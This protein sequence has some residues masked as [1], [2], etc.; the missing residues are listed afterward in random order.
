MEY[1]LQIKNLHKRYKK[2]EFKLDNICLDIPK[3]TVMGFVGTNGAGKSTTIHAMLNIIFKDSGK[4]LFYGEEMTDKSTHL[5]DKIGVVF[6]STYFSGELTPERLDSIFKDIYTEW[7][8]GQ[9]FSY[10]RKLKIP[11]NKKIKTFSRGMTMKL[12]ISVALSHNAKFLILD[13]ATAGLDPV[14]RETILDIF[15]DFMKDPEHAILLSSHITTDLEKIADSISFIDDGILVLTERKEVIK[16]Q[17]GVAQ[18]N[19][20][21]FQNL[22]RDEYV[23]SRSKDGMTYVLVKD[24]FAFKKRHFDAVVT[25]A[26]IDDILPLIS[27]SQ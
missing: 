21:Q 24:R 9:F 7:N 16:A 5:R 3:G 22:Q 25:G 4:V 6:D 27:R 23:G 11:K 13:E 18:L 2:S 15:I 12:S 20:Q 17:Y 8:S 10:L 19:S 26:T 1:A 14:V